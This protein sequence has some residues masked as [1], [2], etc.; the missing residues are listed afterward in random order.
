M[1]FL[2]PW[3]VSP[4]QILHLFIHWNIVIERIYVHDNQGQVIETGL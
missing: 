2:F 1:F 3:F 4:T